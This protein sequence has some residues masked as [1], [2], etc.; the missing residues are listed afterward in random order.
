M[1]ILDFWVRLSKTSFGIRLVMNES[2]SQLRVR[3][4]L[5]AQ[6]YKNSTWLRLIYNNPNV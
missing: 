3:A 2:T 1:Q 5:G 4:E 6:A